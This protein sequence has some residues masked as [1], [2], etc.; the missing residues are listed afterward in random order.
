MDGVVWWGNTEALR[1]SY[2]EPISTSLGEGR[3]TLVTSFKFI[4][5]LPN[6]HLQYNYGR[7]K[8]V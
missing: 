2:L 3:V 8:M 1:Y 4:A 6:I 5:G 7:A